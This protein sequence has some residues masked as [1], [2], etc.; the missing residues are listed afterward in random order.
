MGGDELLM[1]SSVSATFQPYHDYHNYLGAVGLVVRSHDR[2]HPATQACGMMN[3][4]TKVA[5]NKKYLFN[6]NLL[7]KEE[8]YLFI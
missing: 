5:G 7:I 6:H 3:Y 8:I 2:T 4:N 1:L